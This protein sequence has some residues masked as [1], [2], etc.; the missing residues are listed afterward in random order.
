MTSRKAVLP[1][2]NSIEYKLIQL[3]SGPSETRM[4]ALPLVKQARNTPRGVS[5]SYARRYACRIYTYDITR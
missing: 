1:Q 4:Q 5:L 3:V 2:Q